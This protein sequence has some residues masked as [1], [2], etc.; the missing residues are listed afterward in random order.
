M[1]NARG[2]A[3]WSTELVAEVTDAAG[4]EASNDNFLAICS[5]ATLLDLLAHACSTNKPVKALLNH[6]ILKQARI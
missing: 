4:N 5:I 1:Y 2:R 6:A 3:R